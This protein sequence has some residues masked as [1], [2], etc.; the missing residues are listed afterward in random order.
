MDRR[1]KEKE[2]NFAELAVGSYHTSISK[3]EVPACKN[4]CAL[5]QWWHSSKATTEEGQGSIRPG[6]LG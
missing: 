6:L 1:S 2:G 5:S 3:A 4:C